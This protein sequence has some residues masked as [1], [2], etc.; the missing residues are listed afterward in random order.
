MEKQNILPEGQDTQNQ[1]DLN[2]LGQ[3]VSYPQLFQNQESS[4][5]IQNELED[6]SISTI[7]EQTLLKKLSIKRET[8][9]QQYLIAIKENENYNE[10]ISSKNPKILEQ[11]KNSL[12]NDF[13]QKQSQ[14]KQKQTTIFERVPDNQINLL[15]LNYFKQKT[16]IDLTN[17]EKENSK[18][19]TLKHEQQTNNYESDNQQKNSERKIFK[20]DKKC[21]QNDFLPKNTQIQEQQTIIEWVPNNQINCRQ[22]KYFD[23]KNN[24]SLQKNE[25]EHEKEQQLNQEQTNYQGDNYEQQNSDNKTNQQY[26]NYS[27]NDFSIKQDQSKQNQNTRELISNNKISTTQIK[28]TLEKTGRNLQ[29]DDQQHINV[30]NLYDKQISNL[31]NVN[32]EKNTDNDKNQF[33]RQDQQIDDKQ[34]ITQQ[35]DQILKKDILNLE[36][37]YKQ[38]G[39]TYK[40]EPNISCSQTISIVQQQ[41]LSITSQQIDQDIKKYVGKEDNSSPSYSSQLKK[42]FDEIKNY[43]FQEYYKSVELNQITFY[44]Q[45][46]EEEIF[47]RVNE[48]IVSSDQFKS[49]KQKIYE[50][51]KI[52]QLYLCKIL[53]SNQLEDLIIGSNFD[54][55]NN[56]DEYIFKI[57]Y[58]PVQSDIDLQ[59]QIIKTLG[60]QFELIQLEQENIL[61]LGFKKN[62]YL[63]FSNQFELLVQFKSNIQET[64]QNY[65]EINRISCQKCS[66]CQ[67]QNTLK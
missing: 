41:I 44:K 10:H 27:A 34:Q 45:V 42:I 12:Q 19:Q 50:S 64:E 63:S 65:Y 30:Q 29:N 62:D 17:D 56:Y 60:F 15:Q 52:K 26:N 37:I 5:K 22:L 14:T 6:T 18:E 67:D 61:I 57:I 20:Q 21:P 38:K 11:D 35:S 53:Y 39:Q 23:E 48:S 28:E 8:S 31:V 40:E 2:Q 24:V 51:L 58:N 54:N 1:L 16:D 47:D 43:T 4:S 25:Q 66:N 59:S 33:Q 49:Q 3:Q 32:S 36:I 13:S 46:W 55:N 7:S 9:T